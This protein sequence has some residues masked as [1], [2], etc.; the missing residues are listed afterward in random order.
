[1]TNVKL[2]KVEENFAHFEVEFEKDEVE[3]AFKN[4]FRYYSNNI[5]IP[6]FRR[7]KIPAKVIETRLGAAAIIE[8]VTDELKEGA[9][10]NAFKESGLRPRRGDVKWDISGSPMRGEAFSLKFEAP[11]LPQVKLPEI[12]GVEVAFQPQEPDDEMRER[13]LTSLRQRYASYEPVKEGVPVESGHRVEISLSSVF[14]DTGEK[15]P[16]ENEKVTYEAGLEDN[17][18][19]FDENLYGM[20]IGE[21]KTFDYDMPEDFVDERVAGKKLSVTVKVMDA[22]K[23]ELPEVNL[24]F[25]KTHF[26]METQEAFDEYIDGALKYEVENANLARKMELALEQ[27]LA[28]TDIE[29]TP[30]MLAPQIDSMVEEQERS[31]RMSGSS[32]DEILQKQGR[33]IKELRDDFEPRARQLIRRELVISK[34]AADNAIEVNNNELLQRAFRLAQRYNLNRKQAEEL[35]KNRH[36]M[37]QLYGDIVEE[38]VMKL[39]LEKVKFI[40]EDA[41]AAKEVKDESGADFDTIS[42]ESAENIKAADVEEVTSNAPPEAAL[43][44]DKS[45]DGEGETN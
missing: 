12:D 27:V 36:L 44:E 16:F 24:D 20:K 1:M 25:I 37:V 14:A 6:G 38:K 40:E 2:E 32:L 34:M 26:N 7:G 35:L 42:T 10:Q 22:G 23:I 33:T 41:S 5:N 31:L 15:S 28:G 21:T 13:L 30:D 17:L 19:K 4:V 8:V 45:Q 11:V 39:L 18:P 3:R 9:Y 43:E 29:V